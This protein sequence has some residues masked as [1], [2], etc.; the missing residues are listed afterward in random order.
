MRQFSTLGVNLKILM[1]SHQCCFFLR[2]VRQDI[3]THHEAKVMLLLVS[4]ILFT[5]E[6]GV[7]QHALGQDCVYRG[8]CGQGGV[9]YWNAFLLFGGNDTIHLYH[10]IMETKIKMKNCEIGWNGSFYI[11]HS[12]KHC[13][14]TMGSSSNEHDRLFSE[15]M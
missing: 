2:T 15:L 5:V 12:G 8:G 14:F 11:I 6:G 7:S 4:A 9:H 1:I 10:R 3:F 13:L